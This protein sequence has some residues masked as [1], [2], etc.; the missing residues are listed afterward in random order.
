MSVTYQFDESDNTW[1][2][3]LR[4]GA[5]ELRNDWKLDHKIPC[6]AIKILENQEGETA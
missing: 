1:V 3:C 2:A 4:K 6:P 5:D